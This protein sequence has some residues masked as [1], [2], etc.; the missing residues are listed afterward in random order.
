M[1]KYKPIII[2]P[3]FSSEKSM[4]NTEGCLAA[5]GSQP[6]RASAYSV[7]HSVSDCKHSNYDQCYAVN[8]KNILPWIEEYLNKN[9]MKDKCAGIVVTDYVGASGLYNFASFDCTKL[10][11]IVISHNSSNN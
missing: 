7:S 2:V 6:P 4:K 1:Q 5:G 10:P 9:V 8:A 11:G 3:T